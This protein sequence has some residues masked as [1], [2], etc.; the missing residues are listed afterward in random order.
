MTGQVVA[1][2]GW[3]WC[4][5]VVGDEIAAG[6]IEQRCVLTKDSSFRFRPNSA[7]ADPF[8]RVAD[9]SRFLAPTAGLTFACWQFLCAAGN[10]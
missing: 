10:E 2:A 4:S 7:F 9:R 6:C 5:L 3:N 8:R 1:L